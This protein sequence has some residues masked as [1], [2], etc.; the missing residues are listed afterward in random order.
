MRKFLAGKAI[1][2]CTVAN[3]VW[4]PCSD[5][6]KQQG[7]KIRFFPY[8]LQGSWLTPLSKKGIY[9]RKA[10]QIHLSEGFCDREAFRHPWKLL[11]GH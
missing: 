9:K 6:R 2:V 7:E 5:I 3:G 4:V 1:R 11:W 10:E 8:W